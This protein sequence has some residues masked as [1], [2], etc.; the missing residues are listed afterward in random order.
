MRPWDVDDLDG[1]QIFEYPFHD[2]VYDALKFDLRGMKLVNVTLDTTA[3]TST[4]L[5][6]ER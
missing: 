3:T 5:F 6:R 4:T 1:F 2:K